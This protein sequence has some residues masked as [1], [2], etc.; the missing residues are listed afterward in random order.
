MTRPRVK[1]KELAAKRL[2]LFT[3]ISRLRREEYYPEFQNL[4]TL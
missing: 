4:N 3:A 2:F 1:N